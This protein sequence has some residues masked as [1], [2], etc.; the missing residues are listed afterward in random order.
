MPLLYKK[1][2]LYPERWACKCFVS[3]RAEKSRNKGEQSDKMRE[4]SKM[5]CDFTLKNIIIAE[6]PLRISPRSL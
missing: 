3:D 2:G 4:D 6:S 5:K 1:L